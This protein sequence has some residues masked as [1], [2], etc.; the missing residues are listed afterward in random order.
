[1]R[2]A[3]FDQ[4]EPGMIIAREEIFGPVLSVLNWSSYGQLIEL[5]NGSDMGLSAAIWT[6]DIDAALRTASDV[7]AGYVWVNDANRHYLGAPFG[8]LKNSGTG[9][10][11]SIEELESYRQTKSINIRVRPP[12]P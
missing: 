12:S 11:E 4:V 10:E 6:S 8:G 1:M 3:L 5:A 9:R 7:E 2:P